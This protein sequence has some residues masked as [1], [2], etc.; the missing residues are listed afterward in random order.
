MGTD[1]SIFYVQRN[2][3]T[4]NEVE[5]IMF[6]QEWAKDNGASVKRVERLQGVN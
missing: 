5:H 6:W 2:S 1:I 4:I 3:P